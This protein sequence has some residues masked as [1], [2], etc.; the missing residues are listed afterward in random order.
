MIA[1]SLSLASFDRADSLLYVA[2]S[3]RAIAG[4]TV[5]ADPMA[6]IAQVPYAVAHCPEYVARAAS[7]DKLTRLQIME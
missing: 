6:S 7:L 4:A 2:D 1:L 5:A 3:L